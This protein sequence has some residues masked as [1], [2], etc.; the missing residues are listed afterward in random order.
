MKVAIYI[1]VSTEDQA[2][3]DRNERLPR[4]PVHIGGLAMTKNKGGEKYGSKESR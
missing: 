3:K 1:R 4:P 2:K